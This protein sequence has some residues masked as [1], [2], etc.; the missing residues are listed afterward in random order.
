MAVIRLS[1][2]EPADGISCFVIGGCAA[3]GIAMPF[4]CNM[5]SSK[6]M[7]ADSDDT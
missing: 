5:L 2:P 3:G 6:L 1:S 4:C 7:R